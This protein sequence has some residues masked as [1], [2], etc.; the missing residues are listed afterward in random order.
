MG[1][2]NSRAPKPPAAVELNPDTPTP[3]ELVGYLN[4]NAAKITALESRD[5]DL[6]IKAGNQSF[7]VSGTL[8][9]QK[10]R[11]F[12]LRAKM[13]ALR[14]EVADFGSNDQEFWYWIREDKPPDL[15]YCSYADLARGDVRLPFPLQPEWVLEALG[16]AAPAPV[17]TP[18]QEQALGRSFDVRK[19]A[20]NKYVEL[21]ERTRSAQGQPAIKVTTLNNFTASGKTPQVVAHRLY[22]GRGQLVCQATVVS[23]QHD[24]ASGAAVPHKV[25]LKWP[26]QQ[27]GLTMTLGE[28]AVNNPSLGQNPR[29][30]SRPRP[31]DVRQVDL[32]RGLPSMAPAGVQRT[33]AFR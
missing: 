30:F 25:E 4:R 21:I 18:E 29:L 33:G 15:Y 27:M 24:P 20:D 23:V 12:R 19:T 32:A 9:C 6:D 8:F 22:D 16:M 11:N 28:V 17:G 31:E 13:P 3:Q 2:G 1:F 14:R 5:L 26:A 7:G 10:P